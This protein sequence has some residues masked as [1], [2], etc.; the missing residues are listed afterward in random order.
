MKEAL[1]LTQ[2]QR[3]QQRLHPEQMLYGRLLEMSA[4]EIEDEVRRVVD[5]NPALI[6]Q[7][8]D[9]RAEHSGDSES[10]SDHF[11][12]SA[13]E[14]QRADYGSDDEVPFYRYDGGNRGAEA[15]GFDMPAPAPGLTL[16]ES[17][18]AQLADCHL[19]P[20]DRV[21]AEYVVDNLDDNGYLTRSPRAM[22]DDMSAT[23]GVEME[24]DAFRRMLD[25]VRSLDPAGVGA[26]DLRDCMLLQLERIEPVTPAVENAI[27]I[28]RDHFDAFSKRH[29][30]RIKTSMGID[31][32]DLA[33]AVDVIR[34]LDPKP[35]AGADNSTDSRTRYIVPDFTVE[36]EADGRTTVALNGRT[37]ELAIEESFMPD[38]NMAAGSRRDREAYAFVR[39]RYD[40]AR[41]FIK[42][43]DARGRTLMDVMRAIAAR[44]HRFFITADPG[45]IRPMILRD[46][47]ADTGYDLSVI[48]RAT[49]GK[50]VATPAGIYPVKMFFNESPVDDADTSS[51]E[52]MEKIKQLIS[53]EDKGHPL[54]DEA[55]RDALAAEGYDIARRTVAKYRERMGV[56]VARLRKEFK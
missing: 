9:T 15:P 3:L 41:S 36:V 12:E 30:E 18:K 27:K 40:E 42:M 39:A 2:Q 29:A 25:V 53:A 50:Y 33:E 13:E 16:A 45:D 34:S 46:I 56:P 43:L 26:V 8:A 21:V 19:S 38:E 35:G 4:P 24:A 1:N 20:Q 48:S 32:K 6:E 23:S 10:G 11:G 5:E 28:V 31:E 17:L 55:L 7:P 14:L 54:S 51:H 49:A 52:L 44:Q 47:A 22:A 37:P